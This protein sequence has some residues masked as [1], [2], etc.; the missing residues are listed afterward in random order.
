MSDV[1][2]VTSK[3]QVTLPVKIRDALG[4][5]DDSYILFELVGEYVVMKKAELRMREI[6]KIL[7]AAAKRKKITKKELL[8]ALERTKKRMWTA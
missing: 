3:G 7:G 6:Q 5:D 4:I 1:A 2:K 8:E